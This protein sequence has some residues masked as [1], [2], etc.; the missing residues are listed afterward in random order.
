MPELAWTEV[1]RSAMIEPTSQAA[2]AVVMNSAIFVRA[3]GTP[4]ARAA[5]SFPPT[6]KIQLPA[7]DRIRTQVARAVTP[8]HQKIATRKSTPPA[9]T[10]P[11][12]T[13]RAPSY[14][15]A[16]LRPLTCTVPVSALVTP[17]LSPCSMRNVPRVTMKLGSLV[18]TTSRPLAKPIARAR[19]SPAS[20]AAHTF[21]PYLVA[22][23]TITRPVVP[24]STPADRSNSPP[25][26]SRAMATAMMPSVEAGS[27]QLATP[28]ADRKTSDCEEKNAK[29]ATAPTTEPSSGRISRRR[30]HPPPATRS[31]AATLVT[32]CRP[33]RA[34]RPAPRSPWSRTPGRC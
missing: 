29:T 17:R 26:M 23:V 11:A 5:C 22:R 8:S 6:A 32:G 19:T 30:G 15:S 4:T 1:K 20:M 2:V 16:L 21:Q 12:S 14:P 7:L 33:A 34:W 13:A 31:S 24:V 18:R 9:V 3:A 25:I 10:E 27:S 28:S